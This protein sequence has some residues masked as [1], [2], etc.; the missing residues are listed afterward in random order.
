MRSGE[1]LLSEKI[2][3][4][5]PYL[6]TYRPDLCARESFRVLKWPIVTS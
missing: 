6:V 4:A 2:V 1:P 3:H 5:A